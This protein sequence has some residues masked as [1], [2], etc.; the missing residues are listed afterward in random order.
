MEKKRTGSSPGAQE[1]AGI[2]NQKNL[3]ILKTF[4][5]YDDNERFIESLKKNFA[6]LDLNGLDNSAFINVEIK[7]SR[8]NRTEFS[9]VDTAEDLTRQDNMR[10]ILV[11]AFSDLDSIRKVKPKID[12]LLAKE[13]TKFARLPFTPEDAIN[14]LRKNENEKISGQILQEIQDKEIERKVAYLLHA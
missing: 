5:F 11:Y 12:L 14:A 3:E 1:G 7:T 10:K 6:T 13:N 9:G 8:H 4:T 2:G